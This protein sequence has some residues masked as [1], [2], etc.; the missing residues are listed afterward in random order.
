MNENKIYF[1]ARHDA[2]MN[3]RKLVKVFYEKQ[4]AIINAKWMNEEEIGLSTY[5][6][7]EWR[8]YE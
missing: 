6:V 8:K 1:I 4:D 2:V 5:M 7:E 3:E